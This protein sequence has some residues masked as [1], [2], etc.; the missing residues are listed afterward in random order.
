MLIGDVHRGS[1]QFNE[2][3]FLETVEFIRKNDDYY[4]ILMGDLIDKHNKVDSPHDR[5]Y[6]AVE[7]KWPWQSVEWVIN[8]GPL[9]MSSAKVLAEVVTTEERTEREAGGILVSLGG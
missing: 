8:K 7:R 1:K 5:A 9:K 4:T 3:D 6:Y 2:K